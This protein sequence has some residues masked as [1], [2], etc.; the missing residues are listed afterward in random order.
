MITNRTNHY[1][2]LKK[3]NGIPLRAY[4]L[5]QTFAC[6]CLGQMLSLIIND[7]LLPSLKTRNIINS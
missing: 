6:I 4:G 3:L 2:G 5:L 7:E 1:Q